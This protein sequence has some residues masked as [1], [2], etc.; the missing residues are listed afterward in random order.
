MIVRRVV[1][2]TG[3]PCAGKTT[4]AT[5][6]AAESDGQVVDRDLIARALGSRSRHEHGRRITQRA[7]MRMRAELDRI[8]V[9]DVVTAYVVRG[10]PEPGERERLATRLRAEVVLL[11]PGMDECLRRARADQRPDWTEDAIR[12]WYVRAGLAGP[13]SGRVRRSDQ[14]HRSQEW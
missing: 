7:E 3:P 1:L 4:M 14:F 12:Q 11:D 5:A 10:M 6:L 9:A 2:I 13:E 8:A